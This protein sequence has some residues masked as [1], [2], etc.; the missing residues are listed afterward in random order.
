LIE[1]KKGGTHGSIAIWVPTLT[2]WYSS[3]VCLKQVIKLEDF[4]KMAFICEKDKL[5]FKKSKRIASVKSIINSATSF[6]DMKLADSVITPFNFITGLSES[7]CVT[8]RQIILTWIWLFAL[9]QKSMLLDDTSKHAFK[10]K[11]FGRMRDEIEASREIFFV[12]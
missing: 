1:D 8:S 5:Y 12:F 10:I 2:R 3:G 9:T 4:L 7:D 6:E 11:F